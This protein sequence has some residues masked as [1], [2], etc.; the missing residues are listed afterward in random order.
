VDYRG[1]RN[2]AVDTP[3]AASGSVFCVELFVELG[4]RLD[5]LLKNA[6][7]VVDQLALRQLTTKE[8]AEQ[9]FRRGIEATTIGCKIVI[10]SL[11]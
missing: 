5:T 7:G 4:Q 8:F 11:L 10:S 9:L 3:N 6:H 1:E 2:A